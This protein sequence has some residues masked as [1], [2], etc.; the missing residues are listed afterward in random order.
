MIGLG[1]RPVGCSISARLGY[2]QLGARGRLTGLPF[3]HGLLLH[4]RSG[5]RRR[6]RPDNPMRQSF[7]M[8]GRVVARG[9]LG[10]VALVAWAVRPCC[11]ILE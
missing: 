8:L 5:A 7:P 11:Q 4:G 10:D 2:R 3:G 9:E 6:G 1:R